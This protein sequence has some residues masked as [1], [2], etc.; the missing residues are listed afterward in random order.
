MPDVATVGELTPP[1]DLQRTDREGLARRR[2]AQIEAAIERGRAALHRGELEVAHDECLQALT[3]DDSHPGALELEAS[4]TLARDKQRAEALLGEAREELGKKELTA[5]QGLLQQARALD[6]EAADVKRLER[7]L[8]LARVEQERMRQRAD[9]VQ[10]AI[11]VAEQALARTEI[12]AAL[13]FARQALELQPDSEKALALEAEA[14]RRL[15]EETGA[16]TDTGV[17]MPNLAP[18]M[19]SSPP[20]ARAADP[21]MSA[22]PLAGATVVLP[23]TKRTPAPT[24]APT[25]ALPSSPAAASPMAATI[26]SAPAPTAPTI[27]STPA[28]APVAAKPAA[29]VAPVA[30]TVRRPAPAPAK[31]AKVARPRRDYV[32]EL[33]TAVGALQ[34]T[35]AARPQKE[36]MIIGG[37]AAAVV[38]LAA[39][40]AGVLLIPRGAPAT[41]AVLVDA[42]PFATITG[43]EAADGTRPAL[44][45]LAATPLA[46]TLPVGTYKVRLVGPPPA[47]ES[48]LVTV[49]VKADGVAASP[50]E[51]FGTLTPEQYFEQYLSSVA[52]APAEGDQ[53]SATPPAS[54]PADPAA[55]PQGAR[56]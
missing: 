3:L 23:S 11:T 41:G 56:P 43:I 12:E 30:P 1:P 53:P 47:S 51:Q 13:T 36:K 22:P 48:R 42:V 2:T 7:D 4:I 28:P 26:V 46:M 5:A 50:V 52:A 25:V 45:A 16:G 49:E 10:K 24:V 39:I 32:A 31:P 6:P 55:A 37:V 35:I 14:L 34:T 18:T 15:D 44:P 8:R 38:V 40:G 19:L 21:N 20:V 29:A 27:V 9:A 17:G 33:R 54:S